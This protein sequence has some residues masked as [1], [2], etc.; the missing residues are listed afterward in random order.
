MSRL[1]LVVP[2][3][4]IPVV[5]NSVPGG[6]KVESREYKLW[7]RDSPAGTPPSPTRIFKAPFS[8]DPKWSLSTLVRE[9]TGT[10]RRSQE[11]GILSFLSPHIVEPS[12]AAAAVVVVV[13]GNYWEREWREC[14]GCQRE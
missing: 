4:E 12:V 7:C 1:V 9:T 11:I 2:L 8:Q 10:V 3:P 13:A 6:V 14:G 5:D